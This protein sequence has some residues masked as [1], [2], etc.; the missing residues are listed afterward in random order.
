MLNSARKHSGFFLPLLLLLAMACDQ[1]QVEHWGSDG[2]IM[3]L[4]CPDLL[5]VDSAKPDV[6]QPDL[7]LP[8]LPWP[9]LPMPD[10]V[11]SDLPPPDLI[12]GTYNLNVGTHSTA[13][14]DSVF[15]HGFWFVAP[16]DMTLFA[17]LVPTVIQQ[18][19]QSVQVIKFKDKPY[20]GPIYQASKGE[21][22]TLLYTKA[23]KM[24][25]M[26]VNVAIKKGDYIGVLGSRGSSSSTHTVSLTASGP[27]AS[28]IKG[29]PVTLTRLLGG[30][31][32][33]AAKM[34]TVWFTSAN[35]PMGRVE[36][37]YK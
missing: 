17:M 3:D 10:T 32:L 23:A 12:P 22:A 27:M 1:G 19:D 6:A 8:D 13:K 2:P 18:K 34:D 37:R 35:G 14:Q 28:S 25:D 24:S 26:T 9:D 15:T 36:V 11:S 29:T 31:L 7:A 30:G 16:A 4:P 5:A 33:Y 21:Y 20:A